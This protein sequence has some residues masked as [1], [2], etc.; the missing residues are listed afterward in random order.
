[1]LSFGFGLY[2]VAFGLIMALFGQSGAMN[3]L[4]NDQI[5]PAFWDSG[6]VP[7][8][9]AEFQTFIYGVL[10]ATIVGWGVFLAFMARYPFKARE[11]WAWNCI[12]IGMTAWFVVDTIISVRS[13]VGFNVVLNIVFFLLALIPL[14]F[15]RREFRGTSV[16]PV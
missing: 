11:P 8:A 1:V 16:A 9:A 5:D 4:L 3:F 6:D 14:L 12:A 10:G 13:G 7:M 15:T 2:V